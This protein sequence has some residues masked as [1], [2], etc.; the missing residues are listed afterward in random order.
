MIEFS[1]A[2]KRMTSVLRAP[3]GDI[4]VQIKGADSVHVAKA[5]F[6][7]EFGHEQGSGSEVFWCSVRGVEKSYRNDFGVV[8]LAMKNCEE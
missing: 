6:S 3:N 8:L 1:S 2:R 7:Y 4:T 5:N